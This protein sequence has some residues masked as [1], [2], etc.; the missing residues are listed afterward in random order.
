M[1]NSNNTLTHEIVEYVRA[2]PGVSRA[3]IIEGISFD[4]PP[5]QISNML[6]RLKR[7]NALRSEGPYP[8]LNRWFPIETTNNQ[9][10]HQI[11]H[12]LLNEIENVHHE[13]RQ[14]YL[15]TRLE[16]LFGS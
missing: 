4:G 9:M 13:V 14:G 6:G 10:Y 12:D 15:A 1:Y 3:D 8:K 2:N 16:E 7:E 5:L 11:A